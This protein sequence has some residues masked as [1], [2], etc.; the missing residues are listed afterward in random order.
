MASSAM[1]ITQETVEQVAELARLKLSAEDRSRFA[2]DLSNILALVKQLE[3]LNLQDLNLALDAE[4]PTVF[5]AD[6]GER[7]FTR[8]ALLANAPEEEEGF[9]KVPQIL[10]A[11]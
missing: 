11:E 2:E 4:Q 7:Q 6:A 3:A 10:D 9:F 5:R 1:Q 8:D